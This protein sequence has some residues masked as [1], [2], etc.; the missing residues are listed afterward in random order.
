MSSLR[1]TVTFAATC[2]FL[3]LASAAQAT[4]FDLP[5]P[6]PTSDSA[7]LTNCPYSGWSGD[8][9][10]T[11][12]G[13]WYI[14]P[15]Y[16]TTSFQAL[17][18]QSGQSWVGGSH[19]WTWNAPGVD[20]GV[21]PVSGTVLS[22]PATA[23]LPTGC[24]YRPTGSVAHGPELYCGKGAVSPT[25]N[26]LDF[27]L[28]GCVVF[29]ADGNVTGLVTISNSN[30]RNGPNCSVPFGFL[31]KVAGNAGLTLQNDLIDEAWPTFQT[32]LVSTVVVNTISA[33]LTV[34]ETAILNASQ[35]PMG[36][37][38]WGPLDVEN[39]VFIGF[40]LSSTANTGQHGEIFEQGSP[41]PG[42]TYPS[43][44]YRNN[45]VVIPAASALVISA[46]FYPNGLSGKLNIITT[47][48]ADHNVVATNWAGGAGATQATGLSGTVTGQ[49]MTVNPGYAGAISVGTT[50]VRLPGGRAATI[51]SR[52][53][54]T[55]YL[56]SGTVLAGTFTGASTV[57]AT[58]S[59][60]LAEFSYAAAY[61]NVVITSNFVDP[62]GAF[63][64]VRQ[65]SSPILNLTM[66]GNQ[67]LVTGAAI[68]GMGY[69]ASGATCGPLF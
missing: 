3:S 36:G 59:A 69:K 51:L 47:F 18:A 23:R 16:G 12:Q 21:G 27:S 63:S 28:H 6:P 55:Q 10:A 45:I 49:I 34:R 66:S 13:G 2:A 54:A 37:T 42:A 24:V 19:P 46:P 33:P 5:A 61:Q 60:A 44:V 48:V 35:R 14:A 4:P 9:C 57:R 29:L 68:S 8:G 11:A 31:I 43:I 1:L 20:Y 39:S 25:L 41:I 7:N 56:L 53:N 22:D 58:T 52:L 40:T 67:S 15:A 17:A 65:I 64:C 62:T 50:V 32:P 38:S 30:F 26:A